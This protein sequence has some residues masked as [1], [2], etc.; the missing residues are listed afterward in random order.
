[1]SEELNRVAKK[2]N[3]IYNSLNENDKRLELLAVSTTLID[4]LVTFNGLLDVYYKVYKED[5][6]K[7]FEGD[8]LQALTSFEPI[9]D[10]DY[11]KLVDMRNVMVKRAKELRIKM[12]ESSNP[13]LD[14]FN[15]YK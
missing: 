9:S 1:M 14:I 11:D 8:V 6:D 2:R 4:Q 7:M 13:I 5:I 10:C 3:Q 12:E 15:M